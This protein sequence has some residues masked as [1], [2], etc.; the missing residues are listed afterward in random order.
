VKSGAFRVYYEQH[1]KDKLE[2]GTPREH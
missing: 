2:R 1:Y